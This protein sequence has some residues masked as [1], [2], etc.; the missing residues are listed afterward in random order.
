MPFDFSN[1]QGG[2]PDPASQVM[3]DAQQALGLISGIH[4]LFG[5]AVR[6]RKEKSEQRASLKNF[7]GPWFD[8]AFESGVCG[9]PVLDNDKFE[10]HLHKTNG[11]LTPQ[12]SRNLG[13]LWVDLLQALAI[14]PEDDILTWRSAVD[15]PYEMRGTTIALDIR[16]RAFC[17]LINLYRDAPSDY[18]TITI[19]GKQEKGFRCQL[20][21]G[22]LY[23]TDPDAGHVFARF[24]PDTKPKLKTPK[25]PMARVG[26]PAPLDNDRLWKAYEAVWAE[27]NGIS[28]P[29]MAWPNP[30]STPL[31]TRLERLLENIGK[32]RHDKHGL[33]VTRQWL[34]HAS[35][36]K[37]R[38]MSNGGE[39]MRFR[40]D[41]Y[42]TILSHP[43]H[44]SLPQHEKDQ[45]KEQ[46]KSCFFLKGDCFKIRDHKSSDALTSFPPAYVTPRDVLGV[47]LEK[48]AGEHPQS[49]K[50]QLYASRKLVVEVACLKRTII[51]YE[52]GCVRFL[53]F[54]SGDP[55]WNARVHLT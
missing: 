37:R 1:S 26:R 2:S 9:I 35:H 28:D 17:H 52:P 47:T 39:D 3:G 55:L 45:L 41:S 7:F 25:Y 48:Y 19:N 34:S 6:K 27:G 38:V 4:Q 53:Q 18:G 29:T 8:Q 40:Q 12:G 44:W 20:S 22:W 31:H 51:C 43:W 24:E 15:T 11:V 36:I 21:F 16:G 23:W 42:T 49:W 30:E 46:V 54:A 32:L 5:P 10:S 13:S 50:G 33:I 14:N